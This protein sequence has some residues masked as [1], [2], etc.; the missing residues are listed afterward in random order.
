LDGGLI[1]E[2]LFSSRPAD[3][4]A[5]GF[6]SGWFGSSLRNAQRAAGLASQTNETDIEFNHQ[7]QIKPWMYLRPNIQYVIRPNGVPTIRNALVLGIE[8]G[9]TF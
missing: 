9:I 2:G 7:V 3:K 4:T 8:A 6:Y 5:L 1:Y